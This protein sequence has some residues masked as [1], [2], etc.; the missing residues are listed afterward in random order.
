MAKVPPGGRGAEELV[1][2]QAAS[3]VKLPKKTNNKQTTKLAATDT[4][5]GVKVALSAK[6]DGGFSS[7]PP[8][9]VAGPSG[10]ANPT[11]R[12]S[13]SPPSPPPSPAP[14]CV[15]SSKPP[16]LERNERGTH[17]LHII[18]LTVKVFQKKKKKKLASQR[19]NPSVSSERSAVAETDVQEAFLDTRPS[20]P[21]VCAE[22]ERER[23]ETSSER[24][25]PWQRTARCGRRGMGTPAGP[26]GRR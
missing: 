25:L 8:L 1:K 18:F 11:P 13:A 19:G 21:E 14:L 10:C 9:T 15:S 4:L 20:P 26:T 23:G 24:R 12:R 16:S 17:A 6:V 5:L 7:P 3:D 2:R 22:R